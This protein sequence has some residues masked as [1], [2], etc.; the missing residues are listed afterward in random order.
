MAAEAADICPKRC[1]KDTAG[2]MLKMNQVSVAAEAARKEKKVN[3][4]WV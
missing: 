3:A 4:L 1:E 2:V